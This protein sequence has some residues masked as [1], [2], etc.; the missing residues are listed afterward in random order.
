KKGVTIAMNVCSGNTHFVEGMPAAFYNR[1]CL[2]SS[3][4]LEEVEEK[5]DKVAPLGSYHLS[6]ADKNRARSFHLK[7]GRLRELVK[8]EGT[9]VTPL[10]VTN[11]NYAKDGSQFLHMHESGKREEIIKKL[12]R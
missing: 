1:V 7:Q 8:R 11:C 2:E 12:F 4:C 3:S 6:C 9:T 10:I 5:V